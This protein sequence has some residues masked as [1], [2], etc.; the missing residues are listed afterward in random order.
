MILYYIRSNDYFKHFAIDIWLTEAIQRYVLEQLQ[1]QYP[2]LR[3]GSL[4][5]YAGSLH[6]YREDISKWVIF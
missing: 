1:D 3:E 6:A 4:N 2:D 5:Y